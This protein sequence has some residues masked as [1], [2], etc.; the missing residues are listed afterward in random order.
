MKVTPLNPQYVYRR[1]PQ[2]YRLAYVRWSYTE[3]AGVEKA[4]LECSW[5]ENAGL[6]NVAVTVFS[7]VKGC[8]FVRL[9]ICIIVLYIFGTI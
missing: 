9:C 2:T 7:F 1:N 4:A 8:S 5:L 3:N 6:V